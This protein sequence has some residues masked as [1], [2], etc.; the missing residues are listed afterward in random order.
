MTLN[1]ADQEFID[2]MVPHHRQA[3]AM[4]RM[5]LAGGS[6]PRV[7]RLAENVIAAQTAEIKEMLS[8]GARP[9]AGPH[10]SMGMKGARPKP[11]PV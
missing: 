9:A 11:E 5:V 4:A 6:D 8:W 1:A 3:V 10:G 2:R 7:H